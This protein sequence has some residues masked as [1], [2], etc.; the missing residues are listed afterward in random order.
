[1]KRKQQKIILDKDK[2]L[3]REEIFKGKERFHKEQAKLPFEEKIKI[4]VEL[5]KIAR[6][7]KGKGIVWEIESLLPPHGNKQDEEPNEENR[8]KH[9]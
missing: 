2:I 6:N 1:M 7:I 4:L 3:T 9:K 8:N 5:Q